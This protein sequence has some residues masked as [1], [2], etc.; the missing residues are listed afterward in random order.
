[1]AHVPKGDH[2]KPDS[3]LHRSGCVSGPYRV[4]ME[5]LG[6]SSAQEVQERLNENDIDPITDTAGRAD[7]C[8]YNRPEDGDAYL[9]VSAQ[10]ARTLLE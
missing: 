2:I 5:K 3:L 8:R 9:C 4:W 7:D 1:M 10:D 6:A